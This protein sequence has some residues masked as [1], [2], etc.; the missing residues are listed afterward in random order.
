MTPNH[1]VLISLGSNVEPERHIPAAV[2]LLEEDACLNVLAVSSVY[3]TEAVGPPGQP[4]FHNAAM[5][6]ETGLEPPALRLRLRAVEDHLGRVR[7]GDPYAPRT[8]DLDIA[9]IEGVET[10]VEGTPI[11]DPEIPRQAF[12]AVPMAEVAPEWVEPATGWTLRRI[13]EALAEEQEISRMSNRITPINQTSRYALEG[14]ME[15]ITP[16]E[17]YDPV[18]EAPV[19]AQLVELGEDPAREGL[20]RTPL[21]VA[22]AMDFLTSGYT[23]S[24]DEVVNNAI[25]EADTDEMVLVKDVEFYSLCEHHVLPFFGKAHVAYVPRKKIIGLSKIARIVDLFS[26][27]LQVQER[28]TSQ[29]ADAVIEV[30]DPLGVGVVMEGSHFCMMMRGVQKQGSS[31][32]TSAMRGSFKDNPRTR[33]E[34]LDLI[35]RQ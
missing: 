14:R 25:F 33:T 10:E 19:R 13:A 34:F 9:M 5:L 3:R 32:I 1:R 7:T 18:Y 16:D 22:K 26:R 20:L 35:G 24:L 15:E 28:L 12:L 2:E 23:G 21:R 27:R 17:V 8:I 4:P 11:P 30:L 29:I 31:M 6:V